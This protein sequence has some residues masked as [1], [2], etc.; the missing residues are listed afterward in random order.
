M[1]EYNFF[2]PDV[3]NIK[4]MQI[5]VLD[6][7]KNGNILPRDEDEM[8]TTIRSYTAVKIGKKIVGFVALHIHSLV[9]CEIRSLIISS[10]Y[11][12]LGLGKQLI[13]KAINEAKLYKLKEILVL[14]YKE[15]L[16][17]DF[18]FKI[19]QKESIPNSKIWADCIKCKYFPKCD[20][21]GLMLKI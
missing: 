20:E 6:E 11:R 8:A 19:I 13:Q 3:T 9:L 17:L 14:T 2:K 15:K 12:N 7:V 16:F 10:Q 18:N 21:I 1:G 4:N 5:L